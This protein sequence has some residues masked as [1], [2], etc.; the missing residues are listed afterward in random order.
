MDVESE[1]Q[2][3][4]F[5]YVFRSR[6]SAFLLDLAFEVMPDSKTK[7]VLLTVINTAVNRMWE[8]HQ[9]AGRK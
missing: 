4:D 9:K 8:E 1:E 3:S 7:T 5:I 2:M 6:V